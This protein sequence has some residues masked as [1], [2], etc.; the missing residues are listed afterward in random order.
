MRGLDQLEN[1]IRGDFKECVWYEEKG[2]GGV[3]L[4]AVEVEVDVHTSDFGVADCDVSV[5]MLTTGTR[6][7][8]LTV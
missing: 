3:V 5:H 2:Y 7:R 4:E 6:M 1:Y 8:R